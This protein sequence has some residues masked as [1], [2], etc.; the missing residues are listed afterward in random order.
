MK[1]SRC[2]RGSTSVSPRR[3]G[4]GY[5]ILEDRKGGGLR[6]TSSCVE[7]ER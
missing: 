6:E 3:K 4:E 2:N 1:I 5:K 7:G